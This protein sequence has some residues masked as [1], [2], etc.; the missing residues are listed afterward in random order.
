MNL[1]QG[2]LIG[3]ILALGAVAGAM[4]WS[5]L[6]YLFG[7]VIL[8]FILYPVHVRLRQYIGH[9]I[10]AALL[11]ML[12]IVLAI[13]PV[14]AISGIVIED[15]RELSESINQTRFIDVEQTEELIQERTGQEIDIQETINELIQSITTFSVGSFS[16]IL[17][18]V[19]DVAI[20][21]FLMIFL[22]Y[23]FLKDREPFMRW[24]KDLTPFPGHVQDMLYKEMNDTTWAVI[25]GHVLVAIVQGSVAGIGLFV[26]GVPNFIFWT[27]VMIILAFIP[28]I[29][30]VLVWGPAAIYLMVVMGRPT[31]AF[32]LATYGFL[33]VSLI[34]NFLRPIV[35]DRGSDLHPAVI[36]GG[37][38]GGVYLFGVV[39]LFIGP[40]I[41]GVFKSTLTVYRDHYDELQPSGN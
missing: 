8:A 11:V 9:R 7:A 15:A 10:S 29:G 37:V 6:G 24:L 22:L 2:I 14:L 23:Y 12:T 28:I 1:P 4:F 17:T 18:T 38:L 34:D 30:T 21:M 36:L 3:L 32:F 41:L 13:L 27:F 31:A 20:G 33:V 35:V 16:Q 5:F 26:T 25:K 19:V 40:I 39:G